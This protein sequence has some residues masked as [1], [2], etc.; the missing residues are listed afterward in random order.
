MAHK[1]KK[2]KKSDVRNASS[3]KS[4]LVQKNKRR[5]TYAQIAIDEI[6]KITNLDDYNL[7]AHETY[8]NE[9]NYGNKNFLDTVQILESKYKK[10]SETFTS[11]ACFRGLKKLENSRI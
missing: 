3:A 5:P 9:L 11:D 8:I 1:S 10:I 7:E 2:S 6:K 4:N